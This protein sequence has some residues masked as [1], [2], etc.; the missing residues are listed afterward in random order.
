M[1][2]KKWN[3]LPYDRNAALR[4]AAQMNIPPLLAVLLQIRG[5]GDA[6][7]AEEILGGGP[8]LSD[9]LLLPDME[10]AAGRI[11]RALDG[12]EKIAV[13]GDYDADGVTAT[14]MLY[15]YLE[16]CG[17]DVVYY[18]PDRESEGYGLSLSAVDHLNGQGV[19]LIVTVDNGISSVKE[20]EHASSFGIDTVVTDHHR[21]GA[22]L[23]PACAVVDAWRDGCRCPFRDFSGAGVAFQVIAALEGPDGGTEALLEN[24]ADL[25]AIGTIG[26]VVPLTGENR[27]LVRAGLELIAR[28]DRPGIQ[29]LV[30]QSGME[31]SRLTA[32][33]IAFTIVPRINATGRM[34]SADR[35]V[36]LLI[37]ESPEDAGALAAE[38]CAENGNRRRMEDEVFGKV[39]E[40]FEQNPKSQMDRVLVVAG[41]DWHCG[42]IGIVAARVTERFGKP[43]IVISCSG[44]TAKGSGRSIEGFSLFEAVSSCGE[45][46]LKFG[47]HPMAA[48]MTLKTE[49][50]GRFREAVNRYAASLAGPMPFPALA[51]DCALRP[52]K[53]SAEIPDWVCR[54][55]PF[56]TGNPRPV[57]GLMHMTLADITPVG[58]GRHLRLTL[59]KGPA[60]VTCM[61]FRTVLE[62]FGCRIGDEVD[63]AVVLEKKEFNGRPELTV[64][65]RDLRFSG[66][67]TEELLSGRAL[68]EKFR[69]GETLAM[70]EAQRLVPS[71]DDFEAVY[72]A[73]R[74]SGGYSGRPE[75]FLPRIPGG[76]VTL[77]KLLTALDVFA[78]R[79]LIELHKSADTCS[80]RTVRVADKVRLPDSPILSLLQ[81]FCKSR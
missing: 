66:L 52:D 41:E 7:G 18:I 8:V 61:K 56:G 43:C 58:G 46:L 33:N 38:I 23:P 55:E 39:M 17:G 12:F 4:L 51:I 5:A 53:L 63:A 47:G 36:R 50:I 48:G 54:L 71:R 9:P 15:S 73:V 45:L 76:K 34:G 80:I 35:A 14:A 2:I 20:V 42:V 30:E 78:E 28:S 25:A 1:S 77:P 69:R 79:R 70:E 67:D 19:R 74:N 60:A 3:V 64:V 29:A 40:W 72:R 22:V 68:Y 6:R 32:E 44:G 11:N 13:F 75:N 37:S 24:Y 49:N 65:V 10:E 26:D 57:F 81:S 16:S 62:D 27:T 31:N 21:P 59:R